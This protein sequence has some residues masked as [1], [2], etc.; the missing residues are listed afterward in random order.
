MPLNLEQMKALNVSVANCIPGTAI[1][2]GGNSNS[3]W[4]YMGTHGDGTN[5]TAT[6]DKGEE[7]QLV[8]CVSPAIELTKATETEAGGITTLIPVVCHNCRH[9]LGLFAAEDDHS[10]LKMQCPMCGSVIYISNNMLGSYAD[11]PEE[12]TWP[13]VGHW[14]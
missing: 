5:I 2:W 9:P 1:E 7:H 11:H 10:G 4:Q 8:V 14:R 12:H 13:M 3:L 6:D